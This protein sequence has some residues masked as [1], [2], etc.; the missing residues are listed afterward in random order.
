MLTIRPLL[1]LRKHIGMLNLKWDTVIYSEWNYSV[2]GIVFDTVREIMDEFFFQCHHMSR[3]DFVVS[4]PGCG[5]SV[6]NF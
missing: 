3:M 4:P 6:T 1:I 2:V 5:R